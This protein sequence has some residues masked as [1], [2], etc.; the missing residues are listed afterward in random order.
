MN[1]AGKDR[2]KGNPQEYDRSPQG[3]LHRAEDRSKSGDVQKLYQK[4]LPCRHDD[5]VD[6]VVDRNRRR[7]PV[8]RSE[9]VVHEL[10]VRE[11][12]AYQNQQT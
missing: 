7:L 1:R 8:I 10:A 3:S 2:T 4:Q 9:R 11:V 12:S 6:A 5:I